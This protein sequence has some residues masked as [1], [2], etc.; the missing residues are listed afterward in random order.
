MNIVLHFL[1]SLID[2]LKHIDLSG[3]GIFG[4]NNAWTLLLIP[5]VAGFSIQLFKILFRIGS[6]QVNIVHNDKIRSEREAKR[7]AE[8]F[9]PRSYTS[10]RVK[11]K[12]G[13]V[14]TTRWRNS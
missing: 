7:R 1:S 14:T 11:N 12:D 5:F 4:L 2:G 13:T 6:N 10:K 8:S 9:E 3:F